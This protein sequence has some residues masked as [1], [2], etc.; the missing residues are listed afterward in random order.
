ML[1]LSFLY[2]TIY[3]ETFKNIDKTQIFMGLWSSGYDTAS[4]KAKTKSFAF[5]LAVIPGSRDFKFA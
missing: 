3:R 2:S 4:T 5:K 1:S